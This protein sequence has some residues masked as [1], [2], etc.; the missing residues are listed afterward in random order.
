MNTNENNIKNKKNNI[1]AQEFVK[2]KIKCNCIMNKV[3]EDMG[4][5]ELFGLYYIFRIL[6]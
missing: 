6:T 2:P 3:G 4:N 5:N 1:I